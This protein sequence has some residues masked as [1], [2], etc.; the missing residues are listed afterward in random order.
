MCVACYQM[1]SCKEAGH[2]LFEILQHGF[3]NELL[4]LVS[5]TSSSLTSLLFCWQQV[6]LIVAAIGP[7]GKRGGNVASQ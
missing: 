1:R 4:I 7:L 5:V 2:R 3:L 6:I